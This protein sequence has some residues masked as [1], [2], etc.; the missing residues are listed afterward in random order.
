MRSNYSVYATPQFRVLSDGQI[1]NIHLATLEI[2]RRTGVLVF[3]D[4]AL[5]LLQQAGAE[6]DGNRVRIPAG[7]VERALASAPPCVTV[8]DRDGQP[9]MYL[10]DRRAYYGTGS[11]TPY[12]IDLHTGQRRKAVKADVA[13]MARVCDALPHIDFIMCMG[14]ASD[15][16]SPISD[17][18]H[19][20]AMVTNTGKPIVFTAWNLEGLRDIVEMAE[21]VAGGAEAL[22]RNPFAV[23]YAEPSSPLQHSRDAVAKLLYMAEKGLPII[24]TPGLMMG[25]SGPVTL[26]G[27]LA[28][29]NAEIL[30]GL[31]MSQLRQEGAP[32]IYGG[33]T[34]LMEMRT[35]IICYVAPE[36][37][38]NTAALTDMAHHYRLPMFS[39]AACSDSQV[40]DQQAGLE[41]GL[42]TLLA[43]LSG[44]NLCHDVGYI[45]SGLTA[46]FEMLLLGN[47][48]VGFLKRFMQGVQVNEETLALDVIDRVGPGGHFLGEEHTRRH[49]RESWYPSLVDRNNYDTWVEKGSLT[50]GERANRQVRQ[51]LETHQPEPLP[52]EV[53]QKLSD[54]IRRAEERV[55][56]QG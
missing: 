2:L 29:A 38:L 42:W 25:A 4:Q 40:F 21:A 51:I 10:E 48:T 19:F 49:F 52:E 35:T 12:V 31:V 8:C 46:C 26:A 55:Q 37:L 39:F 32:F 15:V 18:H 11:D 53:Q 6:V 44:G 56:A 13:N 20:E 9:A 43:A 33:A 24:Y 28:Q 47:E 22:R 34:A 41:A 23:L 45:G 16:T 27:A 3:D 14:L 17:R 1:E 5:A 54:I 7:L 50:L 30:S 36:F